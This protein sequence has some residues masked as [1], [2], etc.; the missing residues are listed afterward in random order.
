MAFG[1]MAAHQPSTSCGEAT[2][3]NP[4]QANVFQTDSQAAAEFA[5]QKLRNA[6]LKPY[7]LGGFAKA[8]AVYSVNIVEKEAI[9]RVDM[10][11][12]IKIISRSIPKSFHR[13]HVF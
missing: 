11:F 12:H 3:L 4:P 10:G 13:I 6:I 7:V 2:L 9:L 8:Q 1:M 5:V